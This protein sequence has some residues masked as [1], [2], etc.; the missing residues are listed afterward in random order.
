MRILHILDH[1]LPRR[2]AY[3]TRTM[4]ILRQQRA[5]GWHTIHLTGPNQGTAAAFDR[6]SEGWHFFRTERRRSPLARLPLLRELGNLQLM[7][8]RLRRVAKLTRPDLLHAHTVGLDALAALH[9]GRRLRLPVLYEVHCTQDAAEHDVRY[10]MARALETFVAG[11]ADAI[12][13]ATEGM[14][15]ELRVRG[16]AASDITVIPDAL[17][18]R[19][20]EPARA[21][22]PG[23]ARRLGLGAGPVL[24]FVGA[25]YASEGLDLLLDALP[26]LLHAHPG[27]RL[28]LVGAGPHSEALK[29]RAGL[30]GVGASVIF[31]G[32]IASERIA[33]YYPL[34]D[35]LVYP[36]L[37]TRFGALAPATD[38]LEA[39]AQGCLVAA[40]DLGA[41]RDLIRHGWS[42]ILFEAGSTDSLG[43]T[44]RWLLSEPAC[45]PPLRNAAR[46]YVAVERTWAASVARY[47]PLYTDLLERKGG[48]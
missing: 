29:A 37:P 45:W 31:T 32:R 8:R 34:I 46:A 22:D 19:Q 18:P 5:L 14:R 44:L 11:R 39:M 33:R 2:S 40:S 26:Q 9:V 23:L 30:L 25:L 38:A 7:A 15:S 28:L 35:V 24:G 42:G 43:R 48:R 1:S 10:R 3:A 36:R 47:A 27:L 13:T 17:S 21:R 20:L 16:I 12:A 41:H 6:H 4:A